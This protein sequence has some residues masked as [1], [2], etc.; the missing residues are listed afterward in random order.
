MTKITNSFYIRTLCL[1]IFLIVSIKNKAQD[2]LLNQYNL[3]VVNNY[4]LYLQSIR[5]KPH[6]QMA[7]LKKTIKGIV[8]DLR[9]TTLNNFMHTRLYNPQK[10]SFLRVPAAT[11]LAAVQKELHLLGM[12]LKVFDAYRPYSVTEKMWEVVKDERYAAN[13]KY[14]SGHNRGIAVDVTIIYMDTKRELEMGTEFDNFTDTA[15]HAFDKLPKNV[16]QNRR[17]LKSLMEKHGFKS[18]ETEWW[19]YALPDATAYELLNVSF[20]ELAKKFDE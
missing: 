1:V 4:T 6:K 13:P 2:T 17:L 12:G 16:L 11:A 5:A 9:Y 7:D 20:D 19:H 10:T 3:F 18:L 15:H 14:G 8:F